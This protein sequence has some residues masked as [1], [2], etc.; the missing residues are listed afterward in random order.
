MEKGRVGI[1]GTGFISKGLVLALEGNSELTVTN[2]LTRRKIADCMEFPRIEVL[3]NDIDTLIE[4]SDII[5]ECSGDV[6]YG[7]DVI[8][9]CLSASL[10]V[11]TMNA[12]LHVTTGSYFVNKG[13]ITEAEGDQPGCLAILKE[14]AL[15]MGFKPLVYGNIKGFLNHLPTL[16][17]MKFWSKKNGISL[18]MVTASTDGT[19][20]EIEQALVANGLNA[21]ISDDG[22]L[23]IKPVDLISGVNALAE[24]AKNLGTPISDYI[25]YSKPSPSV[26]ITAEHNDNQ[27]EALKYFK[28]GEGPFYTLFANYHLCHL[29]IIKTIKR[30]LNGGGVLLNNSEMPKVSVAAIA[31]R[32]I[33]P[34]EF[35][36]F[37]IG[38]FDVRGKA[39]KIIN[40]IGHIPIGLI[41]NAVVKRNIS[42]GQQIH[43]EDIEIPESLALTAWKRIET[44]AKKIL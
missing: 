26:F 34:G 13:L 5:V 43:F 8:D 25:L 38:S 33:K 20:V 28:M 23:G 9:K 36:P 40:N 35:L 4:G 24:K 42:Q 19:K 31:K 21:D 17:D 37:G 30:V 15:Q 11:V 7:T 22:L 2:V 3:T 27:R 41:K 1:V 16:K 32:S 12:E 18:Q 6:I 14:N 44:M 39:C 29:E 10:P